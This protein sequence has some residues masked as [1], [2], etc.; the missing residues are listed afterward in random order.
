MEQTS[1]L[2]IVVDTKNAKKQID[3]FRKVLVKGETDAK[4]FSTSLDALFSDKTTQKTTKAV[5]TIG[6]AVRGMQ[7][8]LADTVKYMDSFSTHAT[9][10]GEALTKV[11]ASASGTKTA[12]SAIGSLNTQV[13]KIVAQA[14]GLVLMSNSLNKFSR[15]LTTLTTAA[16]G[17]SATASSLATL[18]PR[19]QGLAASTAAATAK[20]SSLASSYTLVNTGLQSNTQ[21][22]ARANQALTANSSVSVKAQLAQDKL[23]AS[24]AKVAAAQSRATAAAT[25][26]EIAAKQLAIA[27]QRLQAAITSRSSVSV[28][29]V[30]TQ[31]A[32]DAAAQ[33]LAASTSRAAG[34]VSNAAN[35]QDRAAVAALRLDA[36]QRRAAAGFDQSNR[37]A[38]GF[39]STLTRLKTLLYTGA[40]AV[41]VIGFVKTAD[42]MQN[43]DSQV[44]LVTKSNEEYLVVREKVRAIAD[45]NFSDIEA[46]TGLYQKSARALSN[47]GKSQKEALV[48]TDAVSLAM[49]TGGRSAGEQAAAILQ[50]GQAMGA[51]VVMGDEFR[52]ISENAPILLE[53]VAKKMGVLPGM[54]K[55]MS[56]EG[57]ITAEV[58]FDALSENIGLLEDMAKKM[59][60]TMAQAFNVAR[61]KYKTYVGDMMNQTGGLS[62]KIAAAL[63]SIS[64]NFE[65]LVKVSMAAAILAFANL[66]TKINIATKAMALFNLVSSANPYVLGIAAILAVASAF[67]GVNDVLDVTYTMLKDLATPIK[68]VG[69]FLKDVATVGVGA[70]KSAYEGITGITELYAD[71]WLMAADAM[72][73]HF[74]EVGKTVAGI[75]RTVE[76]EMRSA[77]LRIQDMFK[78]TT[79]NNKQTSLGFFKEQ[80]KGF[81]GMLQVVTGTFASIGLA[82]TS[83]YSYL[84]S[85]LEDLTYLLGNIGISLVNV[86]KDAENQI[87]HIAYKNETW[88]DKF[89]QQNAFVQKGIYDYAGSV[90][91][92]VNPTGDRVDLSFNS[93]MGKK[94]PTTEANNNVMLKGQSYGD[95]YVLGDGPMSPKNAKDYAAKKLK[96]KTLA[97]EAEAERIRQLQGRADPSKYIKYTNSSATRNMKLSV[98]LEKAMSFLTEVGDAGVTWVVHSGGQPT[99][100]QA[101]ISG[102]KRVGGPRHDLGG[103]GDGYFKYNDTGKRLSWRNAADKKVLAYIAEESAANGANGIGAADNYMGDG[104]FHIGMGGA[105]VWGADKTRKTALPWVA[106]AVDKGNKRKYKSSF[107]GKIDDRA[108][109]EAAEAQAKVKKAADEAERLEKIRLDALEKFNKHRLGLTLEYGTQDAKLQ[110]EHAERVIAI[111]AG[112]FGDTETKDMIAQSEARRVRELADYKNT[113]DEKVT[114]FNRYLMT[115]R[116]MIEAQRLSNVFDVTSNPEMARPENEA[117]LKKALAAIDAEYNFKLDNHNFMVDKQ[118]ADLFDFAKNERDLIVKNQ[119]WELRE[120]GRMTDELS[121]IRVTALLAQHAMVLEKFD[122]AAAKEATLREANENL[123]MLASK[124]N[125]MTKIE[126]LKE[127]SR[128]EIALIQA[129]TDTAAVKIAQE[130]EKVAALNRALENIKV[131][132]EGKYAAITSRQSGGFDKASEQTS[133]KDRLKAD[134]ETLKEARENQLITQA[135]YNAQE[136][137][138]EVE[139]QAAKRELKVM[140]YEGM[141]SSLANSF[142][143]M[144]GEQSKAYKYMFAVEKGFSIARSLMAIQTGIALAAAQPF[145]LNIGAML[146]VAAATGNIVATLRG[147]AMPQLSGQ[148]HDGLAN[149][150]REGTYLLDAGERVVKPRDNQKLTKFLDGEQSG[151]TNGRS[152]VKVFV[153]NM[154]DS[155]VVTT[156]NNDGDLELKIMKAINQH[157]PAQLANPS[158]PIGKSLSGNWQTAPRR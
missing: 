152:D 31:L 77:M 158:S 4:K 67:Y 103:A 35:A 99:K 54:L 149:V 40:S 92:R 62:S 145:P 110:H 26:A 128:L 88:L 127:Q 150:P 135:E 66:A 124:E 22:L 102:A 115:E 140:E 151:G 3:D 24:A 129:G 106:A 17:T 39:N 60:L 156:R 8:D 28:R 139:F 51:G 18:S 27:E 113:L 45:K 61:N 78:E 69:E 74:G 126:Y 94:L 122:E 2:S 133:L 56:R 101:K 137:A 80:Q 44:K 49:R 46:A 116:D 111:Q 25:R 34:A 85:K 121:A 90:N 58:M 41:G 38:Q 65:T 86:F 112:L 146:S 76:S 72:E 147:I 59:P 23:A 148:A 118:E 11:S 109:K 96:D 154:T 117:Y 87:D 10:F 81:A 52:S 100:A 53:L 50:L 108:A 131:E 20:N 42:A 63:I 75:I 36:A 98:Q 153:T 134:L 68:A 119:T 91:R 89:K 30:S 120:A 84:A 123:A 79:D 104:V 107:M 138:L 57:K 12:A 19:L 29:A 37:S 47:L 14:S 5:G 95:V 6:S 16:A 141:A 71:A 48:F 155:Q 21:Y 114:T 132:V 105:G 83:L 97:D 13:T 7:T 157:V 33:R 15:S 64:N 143:D 130:Q 70:V 136:L 144:F 125:H 82:F 73:Y 9:K 1:K 142:K 32:Q 55:E 93:V 43:L